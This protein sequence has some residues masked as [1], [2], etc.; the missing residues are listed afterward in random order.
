MGPI[1]NNQLVENFIDHVKLT[2]DDFLPIDPITLC[3][4]F[5]INCYYSFDEDCP[6]SDEDGIYIRDTWSV[7]HN[8][9]CI[10]KEFVRIMLYTRRG[11]KDKIDIEDE[12]LIKC[13]ARDILVPHKLL[14]RYID[15]GLLLDDLCKSFI[16]DRHVIWRQIDRYN[17][18][19]DRNP[20]SPWI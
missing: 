18:L 7:E 8:R 11:L 3:K 10:V 19:D 15:K 9:Y 13:V 20:N 16:V 4:K 5:N 6:K 2:I 14:R 12:A 17:L 1:I